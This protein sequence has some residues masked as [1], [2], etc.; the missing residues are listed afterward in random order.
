MKELILIF[1]L[2]YSTHVFPQ[3]HRFDSSYTIAHY[4]DHDC[5]NPDFEKMFSTNYFENEYFTFVYEKRNSAGT[6]SGIMFRKVLFENLEDEV[7]VVNDGFMNT[8]P[9]AGHTII[10]WQSD[11]YGNQDI[12]Y[13]TYNGIVWS[14][15]SVLQLTPLDEVNPDVEEIKVPGLN[16]C[17]LILFQRG[18]DI[19]L[20]QIYENNLILDTNLT[21]DISE[22]SSEPRIK[23][24]NEIG[25]QNN[26]YIAYL[27]NVN[28]INRINVLNATINSAYNISFGNSF[29]IVQMKSPADIYIGNS[30]FGRKILQY[31]YDTAG[32]LKNV[33]IYLDNITEKVII[34]NEPGINTGLRGES[35]LQSNYHPVFNACG[36]L[37][38]VNDSSKII[39]T[40]FRPEYGVRKEFYIGDSSIDTRLAMSPYFPKLV[41]NRF[42]YRLVW[43]QV[44][45]G[46]K[47]LKMSIYDEGI[48]GINYLNGSPDKFTL[49]QNYPN[50]FNPST[51][52]KFYLPVSNSLLLEIYDIRGK[53][54]TDLASGRFEYGEHEFKWNAEYYPAGVYF[55]RLM[56][57][58]RTARYT[59]SRKMMLI[60]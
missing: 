25:F 5:L 9:S 40:D 50:P 18:D 38:K 3:F 6:E 41:Y 4:P 11:K 39:A 56:V 55:Y 12:F 1:I 24:N 10:T 42:R 60:K 44:I 30:L 13:S 16:P 59:E 2:L 37:K 58:D 28:G 22:V 7:I 8:E 46:R 35:L 57:N 17:Y 43:E 26:I 51:S 20:K 31:N 48:A 45:S 52:I 49:H 14:E 36:W 23:F 32:S 21:S 19:I 15:P 54:I 29:E 34:N 53:K 27:K 47:S 33:G